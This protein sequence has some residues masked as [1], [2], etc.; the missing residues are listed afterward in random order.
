MTGLDGIEFLSVEQ[1]M[2][3]HHRTIE[4][5]G[6]LAGVRDLGLLEAAVAMPRQRFG[7]NYL[8]DDLAAM[9]GAYLYHLAL[10]H[11][12][13]DGNKRAAVM[14]CLVFLDANGVTNLPGPRAME[15]LTM[16]VADGTMSKT[17]ILEWL[18][19]ALNDPPQ[20]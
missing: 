18:R 1:V 13:H 8:H 4:K 15:R 2:T 14:A 9:A 5:H 7:G 11:P 16:G 10:N 17:Q 20:R 12:F 6:G 3:L 19:A